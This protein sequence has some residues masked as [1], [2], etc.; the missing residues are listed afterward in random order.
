MAETTITEQ[1]TRL[2]KAKDD[3]KI[4]IKAKQPSDATF[5]AARLDEYAAEVDKIVSTKSLTGATVVAS[6]IL[7]DEV[8]YGNNGEKIIGTMAT[9][10]VLPTEITSKDTTVSVGKGYNPEAKTIQIAA[11]EQAKIAAENIKTGITILGTSGT[12]TQEDEAKS[13]TAPY[14]FHGLVG[15]VNGEKVIGTMPEYNGEKELLYI[16]TKLVNDT[17]I[18]PQN[19]KFPSSNSTY[20]YFDGIKGSTEYKVGV[21]ELKVQLSRTDNQRNYQLKSFVG[22]SF[23]A[24]SQI[25]Q[26]PKLFDELYP[27]GT[28]FFTQ[29]NK[30]TIIWNI[31]F[32]NF[33]HTLEYYHNDSMS[34]VN[35]YNIRGIS[36]LSTT[37][38]FNLYYDYNQTQKSGSNFNYNYGFNIVKDDFNKD[39]Y[40]TTENAELSI[41]GVPFP[42]KKGK[43]KVDT[44]I[45]QVYLFYQLPC[46]I[47]YEASQSNFQ[48][49]VSET[50]SNSL[51]WSNLPSNIQS[52]TIHTIKVV[53]TGLDYISKGFITTMNKGVN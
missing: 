7:A 44:I 35:G 20:L 28:G 4:S 6:D 10:N 45:G 17:I 19:V 14:V 9:I 52:G 51:S 33:P 5:S 50:Y 40:F 26:F 29:E 49:I 36:D 12:F 41:F 37:Q 47:M 24:Q 16:D 11:D 42:I 46:D 27:E 15:F 31:P 23:I 25:Y 18:V 8:A 22:N 53:P 3:L 48:P 30:N 32:V 39:L 21:S 2:S 34:G 13:I 1:L 38:I 43:I